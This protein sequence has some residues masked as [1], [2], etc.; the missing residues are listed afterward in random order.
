MKLRFT[1]H[2][3]WIIPVVIVLLFIVFTSFF[4]VAEN[5]RAVV[6]TFGKVSSVRSSGLQFK[7]PY[8]IQDVKKVDMKTQRMSLGYS[9]NSKDGE[10]VSTSE[11]RMITGDYNV[12]SV[13]FFMEWKV[14]DPQKYLYNANQPQGILKNV[15]YAAARDV[16]GSK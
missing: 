7:L 6:T 12:V 3:F 16:I 2:L 4:T 5:E 14:S 10:S 15:A 8:P 13:D 11:S 1:K 9:E